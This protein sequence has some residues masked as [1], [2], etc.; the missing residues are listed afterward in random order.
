MLNFTWSK[1]NDKNK[2]IMHFN[3]GIYILGVSEY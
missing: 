2:L 3:L 1:L